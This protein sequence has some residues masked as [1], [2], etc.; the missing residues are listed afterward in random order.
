M[1]APPVTCKDP[2]PDPLESVA[3]VMETIPE[4]V[5]PV[6]VPKLVIT[7]VFI[8]NEFPVNVKPLPTLR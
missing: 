1:Y 3:L 7:L 6:N 4:L 8:V 2:E 5:K